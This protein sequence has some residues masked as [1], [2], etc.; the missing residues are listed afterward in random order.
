[1]PHACDY[2]DIDGGPFDVPSETTVV[3]HGSYNKTD[4]NIIRIISSLLSGIGEHALGLRQKQDD[5]AVS[6]RTEKHQ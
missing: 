5:L 3:R 1:M 2:E 4:N 6:M